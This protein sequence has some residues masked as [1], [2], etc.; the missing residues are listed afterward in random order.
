MY[1]YR[2]RFYL[3]ELFLS[4]RN[5]FTRNEFYDESSDDN[6]PFRYSLLISKLFQISNLSLFSQSVG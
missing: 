2:F 1:Y 5:L 6:G 3:R 4:L